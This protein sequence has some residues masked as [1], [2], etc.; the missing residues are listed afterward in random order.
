M[1]EYAE[2]FYKSK[3]WQKCREAYFRSQGGLCERCRKRGLLV[4][5][6]TVHHLT[7]I[8]P[9][10]I[11]D[12]NIT[13]S[14]DNLQLLCKDCHAEIHSNNPDYQRRYTVSADGTVKATEDSARPS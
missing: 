4:P 9:Q 6:D 12:P 3:T 5:G 8:T 13:L 10:N 1:K 7:H 2:H 14:F 11:G